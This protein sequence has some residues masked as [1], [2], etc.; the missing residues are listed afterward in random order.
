MRT[1]SK[2]T[3]KMLNKIQSE[4]KKD[5]KHEKNKNNEKLYNSIKINNDRKSWSKIKNTIKPSTKYEYPIL[6]NNEKAI[7][8]KEKTNML[9]NTM[10]EIF[11][12]KDNNQQTNEFERQTNNKAT[13]DLQNFHEKITPIINNNNNNNNNN[14]DKYTTPISQKEIEIITNNLNIHKAAGHD[15]INNRCI[16]N[17][18]ESLIP[19][20][21]LFFNKCLDHGYYP[22]Q[23]KDAKVIMI[24]KPGK[25]R[26]IGKNYRPISLISSIGK[27]M[28]KIIT[29]R[30]YE[31]AEDNNLINE[32]Q[33]G[34][35][36]NRSTQDHIFKL[37][38]SIKQGFN[39]NKTT[40]GIFLDVE[41]AF[42]KIWLNGLRVKLLKFKI[43]TI[44]I[45]GISNFLRNRTMSIQIEDLIYCIKPTHGLP[46]GSP[47][48]P[49]LFILYVSDIP[50]KHKKIELSQFADDI[51]I[52]S[53]STGRRQNEINIQYY[54]TDLESWCKKWRIILNPEETKTINF[55]KSKLK[56]SR[57]NTKLQ[58]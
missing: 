47:L 54:L 8:T 17:I 3:K 10:K 24:P 57:N 30:L 46:Q 36:K 32:E 28:E 5:I 49:I 42:D 45:R 27:I 15:T 2:E 44:L 14:T 52:W 23:W 1:R 34:F 56:K 35:R 50:K 53:T 55:Y 12:S 39:N 6:H 37:T 58:L 41:K 18:Q 40:T 22:N 25:K 26:N 48:S 7:T 51:A 19:V 43:P 31:F 13:L 4:I 11:C 16:K 20:L 33:S 9:G 21:T 29:K 38:Q